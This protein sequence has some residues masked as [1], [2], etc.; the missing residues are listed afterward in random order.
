MAQAVIAGL[1]ALTGQYQ[2]LYTKVIFAEFLFYGLVTAG[3]FLLRRRMPGLPRPYHTWG[4]PLVP[5][6]FVILA[7]SLLI[8]TF[9]EQRSDSL[10]GLALMGSGIPAYFLWSLWKKRSYAT[11]SDTGPEAN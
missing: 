4:Y 6:I 10:W 1:F 3:I 9:R 5:A 11:R 8:N 7:A 2:G